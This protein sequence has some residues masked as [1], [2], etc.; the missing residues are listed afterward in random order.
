MLAGNP[1]LLAKNASVPTTFAS[2]G[3]P[4]TMNAIPADEFLLAG[5]QTIL[6]SVAVV[7][8]SIYSSNNYVM[9]IK[10]FVIQLYDDD[11]NPRNKIWHSWIVLHTNVATKSMFLISG[12]EGTPTGALQQYGFAALEITHILDLSMPYRHQHKSLLFFLQ[13]QYRLSS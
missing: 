6:I 12:N 2:L 1:T 11:Y 13:F 7:T 10:Y 8:C 4:C 3:R 5:A 9:F